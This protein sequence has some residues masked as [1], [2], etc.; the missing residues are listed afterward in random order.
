MLPERPVTS[1]DPRLPIHAWT[2]T[3]AVV[4]GV[5]YHNDPARSD[6]APKS[7]KQSEIRSRSGV[8]EWLVSADSPAPGPA[9]STTLASVTSLT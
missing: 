9:S 8:V 7:P 4:L 6:R 5:E 1:H 3:F 2:P